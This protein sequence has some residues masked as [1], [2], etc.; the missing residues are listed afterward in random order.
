MGK[1]SFTGFENFAFIPYAPETVKES[2]EFDTDVVIT[3]DGSEDRAPTRATARQTYRYE[4]DASIV[5]AQSPFNLFDQNIRGDWAVPLWSEAQY[6]GTVSGTTIACNTVISD[7]RADSLVLVFKNNDSWQVRQIDSIAEGVLT[8]TAS[9]TAMTGAYVIPIRPATVLGNVGQQVSSANLRYSVVYELSDPRPY[10]TYIGVMFILDHSDIMFGHSLDRSKASLLD[11]LAM[12]SGAVV[13]SGVKLDL[14]ICQWASNAVTTSWL[15]ATAADI[16]EA[17]ALVTATTATSEMEPD[18]AE[19]MTAARTF[20]ETTTPNPGGRYDYL[21]YITGS[22]A[23]TTAAA[24]ASSA[25]LNGTGA[26]SGTRGVQSRSIIFSQDSAHTAGQQRELVNNWSNLQAGVDNWSNDSATG[27]DS[28]ETFGGFSNAYELGLS[29]AGQRRQLDSIDVSFR[30]PYQVRGWFK[31]GSTGGTGARLLLR[32]N[33][34]DDEIRGDFATPAI[35]EEE[36]GVIEN[37]TST[38]LGGGVWLWSFDTTLSY[39]LDNVIIALGNATSAQSVILFAASL[40]RQF[41]SDPPTESAMLLDNTGEAI[42][43]VGDTTT[44]ALFFCIQR[45]LA[46]TIGYQYGGF[47]IITDEPNGDAMTK[48]INKI[49]NRVDFGGAF[50]TLSPWLYSRIISAHA[51]PKDSLEELRQFKEFIYRRLGKFRPVYLPT[52]QY[53]LH[54]TAI[55]VDQYTATCPASDIREYNSNRT[56]VVIKWDDGFW[57][58]L[59]IGAVD[60]IGGGLVEVTFN[61]KMLGTEAS[62]IR[63]TSFIGEGRFD[64]DRIEVTW[65]GYQTTDTTINLVEIS[66]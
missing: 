29:G 37:I 5:N 31:S 27:A 53:D 34:L 64:T 16:A 11:A 43:V 30:T 22:N 41:Q 17:I 65:S 54:I 23:D 21:F 10:Q 9:L 1:L 14:A 51:F 62:Q 56:R 7:F 58:G 39:H 32:R 45:A 19:A 55:S 46:P 13:N 42:T 12:L 4:F 26:Y 3:H 6:V 49:E 48:N 52:F 18:P 33:G 35:L 8:L 2:L 66:K 63:Q 60:D 20:F 15:D 40:R 36:L 61:E 59:T 44:D 25:L 47:E 50:T 38:D 57:Q 24:S 28:A